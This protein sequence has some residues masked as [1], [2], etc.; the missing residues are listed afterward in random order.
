MNSATGDGSASTLWDN[1]D[2]WRL[3]ENCGRDEPLYTNANY[4]RH[5]TPHARVLVIL[6]QPT[7]RSVPMSPPVQ[8]GIHEPHAPN[9]TRT[10][11]PTFDTP[12]YAGRSNS[13]YHSTVRI[14]CHEFRSRLAHAVFSLHVESAYRSEC[15]A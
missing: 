9:H 15:F 13:S 7:D 4:I 10:V 2:W 14:G 8:H 3:P 11:Y 1:D 5:L 6:R 12:Q